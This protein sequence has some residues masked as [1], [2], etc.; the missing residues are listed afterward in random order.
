[1]QPALKLPSDTLAET[2][3]NSPPELTSTPEGQANDQ[4]AEEHS[5]EVSNPTTKTVEIETV[6]SENPSDLSSTALETDRPEETMASCPDNQTNETPFVDDLEEALLVAISEQV[7]PEPVPRE[8]PVDRDSGVIALTC[9]SEPEFESLVEGAELA[10]GIDFTKL[11][12]G[13]KINF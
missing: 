4:P 6:H 3:D 2:Q 7:N 8:Q 9:K 1:V 11:R 13:R 12:F 10:L 5:K